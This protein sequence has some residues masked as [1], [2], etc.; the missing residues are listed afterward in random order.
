MLMAGWPDTS[1]IMGSHLLAS[2]FLQELQEQNLINPI[3]LYISNAEFS[4]WHSQQP[5]SGCGAWASH[6]S[7]FSCCG[8]GAL[9]Q[10]GFRSCGMWAQ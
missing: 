3:H 6:F 10:V 4:A 8:A 9:G 5:L 2:E 1:F 7:S